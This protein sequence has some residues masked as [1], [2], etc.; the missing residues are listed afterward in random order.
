MVINPADVKDMLAKAKAQNA[1][2]AWY[3]I[4]IENLIWD[5]AWV[6]ATLKA[7]GRGFIE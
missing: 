3:M 2:G 5:R 4:D 6:D 1:K 7:K